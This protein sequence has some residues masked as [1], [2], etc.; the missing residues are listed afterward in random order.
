MTMSDRVAVM[1]GGQI[2]QMGTPADVYRAPCDT[3]VASFLGETNL[4]PCVVRGR[5]GDRAVVA[6][7]DGT[8]GGANSRAMSSGSAVVSVRPERICVVDEHT[9]VDNSV[10]GVVET[11]VFTGSSIRYTIKALG[12]DVIV[13]CLDSGAPPLMPGESVR[14][15]WNSDDA[16]VVVPELGAP[17]DAERA[18]TAVATR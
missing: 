16:Q 7:G 3:F 12:T 13:R 10:G 8:V 15:G 5:D 2:V 1:N 18:N 14:I 6:Y 11:G 4:I 17:T 9:Q